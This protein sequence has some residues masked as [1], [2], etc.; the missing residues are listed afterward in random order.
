MRLEKASSKAIRY[1]CMNF[2]YAKAV[3]YCSTGY[4]VFNEVN[5]FCGVI[6]FNRGS[7]NGGKPYNLVIG[8]F[9]ELIRVALNGKH[10]ITTKA[11]SIA[12]RLFKKDNPNVKIL[13]SYADTG[14]CHNGVIYQA[15]NWFYEGEI[16]PSRPFFKDKNGKMIHSRT[17]A[18][19][20]QTGKIKHY[21]D[22]L[23]RIT[24]TNKHRYIYPLDRSMIQMCKDLS[25]PYPK[26]QHAGEA[27]LEV[28]QA[29]SLE[30]AFDATAP[31][32]K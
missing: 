14:Q 20:K 24:N 8:Q 18:K 28:C 5:E 11:V 19:M 26:K 7:R 6:L 9:A 13:I 4:T 31:L 15:M 21:D 17:A 25:K 3:P 12:L 1:A 2:H 29:A 27:L 16:E 30:E 32:K 23:E 10:G 22:G